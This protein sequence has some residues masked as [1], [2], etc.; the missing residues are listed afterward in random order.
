MYQNRPPGVSFSSKLSTRLS[1]YYQ[2]RPPGVTI[3]TDYQKVTLVS[4]LDTRGHFCPIALFTP[5]LG[6]HYTCKVY[7]TRKTSQLTS[8]HRVISPFDTN[9][10]SKQANNTR[11]HYNYNAKKKIKKHN[12]IHKKCLHETETTTPT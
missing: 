10:S 3:K 9:N 6:T 4:N 11:N 5:L 2:N 1:L 12:T 7:L 8:F